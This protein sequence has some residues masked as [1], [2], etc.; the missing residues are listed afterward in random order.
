M[1]ANLDHGIN[2]YSRSS[3]IRR[4]CVDKD[5]LLYQF[6]SIMLNL[7]TISD[8]GNPLEYNLKLLSQS[9]RRNIYVKKLQQ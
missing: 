8:G 6:Y 1:G 2:G 5:C 9:I 3:K 4:Q 7:K